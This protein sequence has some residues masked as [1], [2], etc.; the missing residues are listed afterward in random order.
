MSLWRDPSRTVAYLQ[1]IL[2]LNAVRVVGRGAGDQVA[3]L[4]MES[5]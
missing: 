1:W 3:E 4:A 5:I 2:E